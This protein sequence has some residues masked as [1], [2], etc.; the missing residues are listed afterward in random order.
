ME[1]LKRDI[2]YYTLFEERLLARKV[3]DIMLKIE[4]I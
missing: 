1:S 4:I 3:T 2:L